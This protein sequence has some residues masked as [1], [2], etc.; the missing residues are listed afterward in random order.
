M[1]NYQLPE[2]LNTTQV[3]YEKWLSRKA[4]SIKVRAFK[5]DKIKHAGLE[6]IK[7]AIHD[8]VKKSNGRDFYTGEKLDW[9]LLGKWDNEKSKEN[10]VEYIKKFALAPSVDHYSGR[11]KLNF[12]ICSRIVNDAKNYLSH[13]EFI[14][15]CRKVIKHFDK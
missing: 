15:L 1:R 7:K 10:G 13:E 8:A 9:S 2:N 4:R 11:N 5:K 14:S 6:F 3:V 12:V